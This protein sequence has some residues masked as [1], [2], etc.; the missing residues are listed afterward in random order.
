[1]SRRLA[2]FRN[3]RSGSA[4][5]PGRLEAAVERAHI[6]A[7]VHDLPSGRISE[8]VAARADG[9]DVLAA[10]GG[11]GTV[12][13]VAAAVLGTGKTLAVIPAGTSNHFARDTG[14]PLDVEGALGLIAA[15]PATLLDVGVANDRIFV[16][17]ASFGVYPRMVGERDRARRRG[18]PRR[19]ASAI[20]VFDA[21]LELHNIAVRLRVDG[22]EFVRRTPFVVVGNN[23]YK[24]EGLVLGRRPTLNAGRLSLYVAPGLGRPGAL[25]LPI[26]ALLGRLETHQKFEAWTA[27]TLSVHTAGPQITVALDGEVQ[28][29]QTPVRFAT[30]P[31]ALRA[32]VPAAEAR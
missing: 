19:V 30:R 25:A 6:E 1:V 2:I 5:D 14:I 29:L 3:P 31:A 11:D 15:G 16:N 10:A 12:S 18:L 13:A 32:I 24:V 4:L 17:N 23:E 9:Y 7:D 26:R 20:A 22:H 8:T 21:W 27:T 28:P